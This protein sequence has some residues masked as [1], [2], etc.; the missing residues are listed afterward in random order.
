MNGGG[1][2][3]LGVGWGGLAAAALVATGCGSGSGARCAAGTM[4]E[5]DACAPVPI[6][7]G[8]SDALGMDSVTQMTPT[9]ASSDAGFTGWGPLPVPGRSRS[10]CPQ[11]AR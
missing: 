6:D 2:K 10:R 4:Q 9:D 3:I 11:G 7:G 5:G 1:W 8:P